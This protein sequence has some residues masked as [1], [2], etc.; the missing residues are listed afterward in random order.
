MQGDNLLSGDVYNE[1]ESA[2]DF[3]ASVLAWRALGQKPTQAVV[4][5][6]SFVVVKEDV[7]ISAGMISDTEKYER[8]KNA[9]LAQ[10]KFTTTVRPAIVDTYLPLSSLYLPKAAT[11]TTH[12][13]SDENTCSDD[14]ASPI[15]ESLLDATVSELTTK[16][17]E[18][19]MHVQEQVPAI[20]S[21]VVMEVNVEE[22][23]DVV[24]C[25]IDEEVANKYLVTEPPE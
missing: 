5:E 23:T 14:D 4:V 9:A 6:P 8:A 25:L 18:N 12:H 22:N 10:I 13:F 15:E 16:V 24:E 7:G 20:L 3:Q 11:A 2:A 19:I 17:A 21:V 1:A